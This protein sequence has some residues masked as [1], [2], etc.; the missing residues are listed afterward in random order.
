MLDVINL[1]GERLVG[2]REE[3]EVETATHRSACEI[4]MCGI[5]HRAFQIASRLKTD[6]WLEVNS[7]AVTEH[8]GNKKQ[9]YCL[10][11]G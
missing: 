8:P 7:I 5:T 10:R 6:K 3:V 9:T 11:G 1:K 2:L 4:P